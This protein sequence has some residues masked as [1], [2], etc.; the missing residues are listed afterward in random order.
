MSA[1]HTVPLRIRESYT[2]IATRIATRSETRETLVVGLTAMLH[3]HDE[4]H[5][6]LD[7]V[8]G[9]IAANPNAIEVFIPDQLP[10]ADRAR[11][12]GKGLNPG[13][14]PLLE[15]RGK[16]R[17]FFPDRVFA[18]DVIRH[19]RLALILAELVRAEQF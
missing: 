1:V 10:D 12:F 18:E 16:G 11:A 4:Q 5:F 17:E 9:V 19:Y 8:D 2:R 14:F 15:R 3:H 13:V 6:I 7:L